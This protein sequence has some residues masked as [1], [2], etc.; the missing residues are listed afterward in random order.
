MIRGVS[1]QAWTSLAIGGAL[2]ILSMF[3]FF[4][5]YGSGPSFPPV[6]FYTWPVSVIGGVMVGYAVA[7]LASLGEGRLLRIGLALLGGIAAWTGQL[8]IQAVVSPAVVFRP[9]DLTN[10]RMGLAIAV[11]I[12]VLVEVWVGY[13][14][15]RSAG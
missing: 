3:L 5:I 4:V 9:A 14:V 1:P 15:P 6:Q 12:V 11:V 10:Y 13:N 7:D 2:V 8:L